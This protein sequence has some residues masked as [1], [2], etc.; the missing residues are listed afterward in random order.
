MQFST[1][2]LFKGELERNISP[3]EEEIRELYKFISDYQLCTDDDLEKLI[4]VRLMAAYEEALVKYL[5]PDNSLKLANY[6]AEA[7]HLGSIV[8]KIVQ[9]FVRS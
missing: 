6:K 9:T 8:E 4:T 1:W 2:E 3:N 5:H 7:I